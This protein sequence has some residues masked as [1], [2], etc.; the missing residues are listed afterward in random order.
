MERGWEKREERYPGRWLWL[1]PPLN[2][3]GTEQAGL[4]ALPC[5]PGA[6]GPKFAAGAGRVG[7][8]EA[9]A[10]GGIRVARQGVQCIPAPSGHRARKLL[11]P[12]PGHRLVCDLL[13]W[14]A[15]GGRLEDGREDRWEDRQPLRRRRR[16]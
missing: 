4:R 9:V 2:L 15:G 14:P 8:P 1:G 11:E 13:T 5:G 3:A 7:F 16:D 6:R 10:V 12:S